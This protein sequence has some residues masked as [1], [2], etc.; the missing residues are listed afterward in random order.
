MF[1]FGIIKQLVDDIPPFPG[2]VPEFTP[3]R[4]YRDIVDKVPEKKVHWTQDR[5]DFRDYYDYSKGDSCILRFEAFPEDVRDYFKCF[6]LDNIDQGG[7]ATTEAGRLMRLQKVFGEALKQTPTHRF[8]DIDGVTLSS[9]IDVQWNDSYKTK[10]MVY[11]D[12]LMLLDFFRNELHV[13][14]DINPEYIEDCRT[15]LSDLTAGYDGEK[16]SVY[17]PEEKMEEIIDGLDDVMRDEEVPLHDR[18]T[19]GMTLLDTQLGLRNA[20]ITALE[21]DCL[22]EVECLDGKVRDY[23]V[24]NAL[25]AVRVGNQAT[26]T[27]TICT[28]LAKQT[29]Q[30]LLELREKVPGHENNR[31][32]YIQNKRCADGKVF[33]K[34]RFRERYRHICAKY[35]KEIFKN[36]I[37]GIGLTRVYVTN[38]KKEKYRYVDLYLPNVYCYRVTFASTL[39]AQGLH[40]DYINAI[41]SHKP[42]SNV[43]DAYIVNTE[44]PDGAT[45]ELEQIF[46]N[47]AIPNE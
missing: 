29:I 44:L 2:L 30:Y 12:I 22:H 33:N 11:G 27:K 5:M 37:P 20:E 42:G 32:M 43:D 14:L 31:F 3:C 6:C 47:N 38:Y 13:F 18:I 21:A 26:P 19:A 16:H 15:F 46:E 41:M 35:L 40:I 45:D 39:Y 28:P 4:S 25:K 9:A 36:P 24:Y 34:E 10:M 7:K 23:I 8:F 17:L 1:D